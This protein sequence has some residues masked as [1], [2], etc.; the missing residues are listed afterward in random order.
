MG[1]L[2]FTMTMSKNEV[3]MSS[4]TEKQLDFFY[5]FPGWLIFFWA[6]A[7][8]AS[9]LGSVLLLFRSKLA[10]PVLAASFVSMVIVSVHNFGFSNGLELM[11]AGGAIFSEVIFL[12]A[13]LL[14]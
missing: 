7:V 13:L 3:W 5:G 4:F 12:I 2:D 1:A 14:V 9:L 11:G 10:L 6:I 8:W